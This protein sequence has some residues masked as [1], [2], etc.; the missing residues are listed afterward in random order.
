MLK[1][2]AHSMGEADHAGAGGLAIVFGVSGEQR[3]V[4]DLFVVGQGKAGG[5]ILG[6]ERMF[7]NVAAAVQQ[8]LK[9]SETATP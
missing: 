2:P 4:Q 1:P 3:H 8:F 9:G 7:F 5:L 6:R